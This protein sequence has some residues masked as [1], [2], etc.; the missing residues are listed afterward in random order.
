MRYRCLVLQ[1]M[2]ILERDFTVR[3]PAC[4]GVL[5]IESGWRRKQ[6]MLLVFDEVELQSITRLEAIYH[7]LE[8]NL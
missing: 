7:A 3:C 8:K 1:G 5:W 4:G 6:G 2:W